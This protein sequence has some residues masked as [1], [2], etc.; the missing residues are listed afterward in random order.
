MK[1]R[2]VALVLMVF[3]NA[4]VSAQ[5]SLVGRYSG[6]FMGAGSSGQ[7]GVGMDLTITNV[8]GEKV[9]ATALRHT[10]YAPPGCGSVH[11]LEGTYQ[12]KRLELTGTGACQ[13]R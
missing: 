5:D 7:V 3:G 9:K 10:R 4:P 13:T 6:T 12:D 2:T 1:L 11:P 8:E